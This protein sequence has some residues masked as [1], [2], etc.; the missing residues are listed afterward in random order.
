MWLQF[1]AYKY[2]CS[3]R[4]SVSLTTWEMSLAFFLELFLTLLPLD[5]VQLAKVTHIVKCLLYIHP[6][7]CFNPKFF[8][9]PLGRLLPNPGERC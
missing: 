7:R 9:K 8:L 4:N 3:T 1:S 6:P 5:H 2:V